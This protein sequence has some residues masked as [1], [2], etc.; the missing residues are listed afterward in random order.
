MDIDDWRSH[1]GRLGI[2]GEKQTRPM[3]TMSD[4]FRTRVV[5]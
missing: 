1:L 3:K 4:G 5:F 2:T